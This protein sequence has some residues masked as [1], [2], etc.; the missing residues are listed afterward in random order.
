[1]VIYEHLYLSD[2]EKKSSMELLHDI[3]DHLLSN[4]R[5]LTNQIQ[6]K[7]GEAFMNMAVAS[8]Y[9]HADGHSGVHYGQRQRRDTRSKRS[10]STSSG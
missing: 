1:M 6:E 5:S 9:R 7:V 10:S 3:L 4:Q 8:R 2:H